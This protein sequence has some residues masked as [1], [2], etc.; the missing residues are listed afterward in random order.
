MLYYA[1]FF[2]AYQIKD[3]N[4]AKAKEYVTKSLQFNPS[5]QDAI[6]LD[7]ALK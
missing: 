3:S 1:Y 4:P 6:N 7:K 5:F 2:V